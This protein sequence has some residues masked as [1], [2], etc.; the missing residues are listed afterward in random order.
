MFLSKG[1]TGPGYTV[2][3]AKVNRTLTAGQRKALMKLRNLDGYTSAP[4]YI[5]SQA[6]SDTPAMPNTDSYFFSPKTE[7]AP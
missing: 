1:T 4:C 6:M 2:A 7:R 5:Y 3:F